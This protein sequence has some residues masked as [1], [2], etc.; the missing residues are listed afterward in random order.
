MVNSSD[1][2]GYTPLIEACIHGHCNVVAVLL[3]NGNANIEVIE[4]GTGTNATALHYASKYGFTDCMQMLIK[5]GANVNAQ[6]DMG[7]TPLHEA[8]LKVYLLSFSSSLLSCFYHL[9][10]SSVLCCVVLCFDVI[11][12]KW[13]QASVY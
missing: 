9:F 12:I 13:N 8:A 6:D 10:F 3:T 11:R 7:W 1:G 5:N 2:F 4:L